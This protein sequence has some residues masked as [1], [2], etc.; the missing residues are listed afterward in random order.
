MIVAID[1]PAGAG[2]STIAHRVAH[3]LGFQ[4]VDTGAIYRAVAYR[5][6]EDGEDLDDPAGVSTLAAS[7]HFDF[8]RDEAGENVLIC[9]GEPL[10]TEIRTPTVTRATSMISGYT[11]VRQ[12]LLDIQ[13]DIGRRE[14]SVL[15]GR[16]IGTVVFPDAEVK[17][18]LTAS[19]EVRAHRRLEQM[20]EQ[21]MEADLDEVYDEIVERDKRDT[22]RDIAPLV[23][24]DDAVEVDTTGLEIEEVV[25]QIL[26]I[27]RAGE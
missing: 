27:V 14:S 6:I 5:A 7:L 17:I 25:A 21:G 11:A 23:K 16:D 24:A 22:E 19:K 15:E 20:K 26:E 13:R 3:E 2:K 12:A 8:K 4:L 1:G 10:G 9:D 18:F